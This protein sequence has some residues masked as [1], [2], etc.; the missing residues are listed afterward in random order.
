MDAPISRT[1]PYE[2]PP[3]PLGPDD[4][5]EPLAAETSRLR[6]SPF[7]RRSSME[8]RHPR[9]SGP[10]RN[11]FRPRSSP[12]STVT[13]ESASRCSA[14]SFKPQRPSNGHGSGCPLSRAR[15]LGIYCEDSRGELWRRQADINAAYGCDFAALRDVHWLPRLG[16]DNVL[17]TFT[18]K[19]VG[20]LTKFHGQVLGM[21]LDLQRP[22]CNFRYRRGRFCRQRERPRPG[23]AIRSKSMRKHRAQKS[24]EA[25]LSRRIQAV[26]GIKSG[27]GDG[28]S[29]GWSNAFRSRLY[30]REPTTENGETLDKDA[31]ILERRKANY[32]SRNEELRLRW[33]KA[34]SSRRRP[35]SAGVTAFGKVDPIDVFLSL[36]R[37]FGE[38]ER[39]VSVNTRAGNYAPRVFGRLPPTNAATYR[40]ADFRRAMEEAFAKGKIENAPYGR[41]GDERRKLVIAEAPA[42]GKWRTRRRQWLNAAV[43]RRFDRGYNRRTT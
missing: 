4:Y 33:R 18:S 5:G 43:L 21:A 25:S 19:G 9:A 10:C 32:A 30:L 27:E 29:T 37:Q 22:P 20:E 36:V 16:E 40:E 3:P 24:A 2:P 13:A 1:R 12:A 11:G 41:K 14:S 26:A 38:Q 35:F 31:R 39:D 34:S 28:G 15:A 23:A 8:R 6:S 7:H 17:M 42:D